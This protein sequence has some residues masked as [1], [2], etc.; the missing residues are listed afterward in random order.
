MN[1][2]TFAGIITTELDI[3]FVGDGDNQQPVCKFLIEIADRKGERT[4]M[5]AQVW[6]REVEQFSREFSKGCSGVFTGR[7][8]IETRETDGGA[9]NKV[10]Q[11]SV[12]QYQKIGGAASPVVQ[13][14]IPF[15]VRAERPK[16]LEGMIED[17]PDFD[18]IPF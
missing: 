2:A 10:P 7:L 15:A 13:T 16:P 6:G 11:L 1:N 18:D 17:N 14:E 9:K 4:A 5:E 8:R 3:K 12:S